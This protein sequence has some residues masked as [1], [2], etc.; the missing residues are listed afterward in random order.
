MCMEVLNS[1]KSTVHFMCHHS[2]T[3]TRLIVSFRESDYLDVPITF[4][5][6]QLQ[7]NC[8]YGIST[9]TVTCLSELSTRSWSK[10]CLKSQGNDWHLVCIQMHLFFRSTD[11]FSWGEAVNAGGNCTFSGL[12]SLGIKR[13]NRIIISRDVKML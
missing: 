12:S 10:M 9:R 11:C 2:L 5:P 3:A 13:T 6:R 7:N 1:Q 4:G 8:W